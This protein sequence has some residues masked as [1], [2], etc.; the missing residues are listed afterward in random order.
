MVMR[1][2]GKGE[3]KG[4]GEKKKKV[5]SSHSQSVIKSKRISRAAKVKQLSQRL[6][7]REEKKK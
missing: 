2:E 7:R 5:S 6:R 1:G 3:G 4:K